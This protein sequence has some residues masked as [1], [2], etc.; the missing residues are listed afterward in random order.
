MTELFFVSRT[1]KRCFFSWLLS[2]G[3]EKPD[4]CND[5]SCRQYYSDIDDVK[6]NNERVNELDSTR[7]VGIL[8][9]RRAPNA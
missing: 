7:D 3:R 5:R 8:S 2:K 6:V 1:T 9:H 4:I